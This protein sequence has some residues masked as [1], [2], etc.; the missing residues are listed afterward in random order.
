MEIGLLALGIRLALPLRVAC[1]THRPGKT[2]VTSLVLASTVQ[3]P[4]VAVNPRVSSAA[5]GGLNATTIG[6]VEV[7]PAMTD[8]GTPI[9]NDVAAL[10]M[11]T[12]QLCTAWASTPATPVAVAL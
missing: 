3:M 2:P 8:D 1:T 6:C 12:V 5:N 4:E 11:F 9:D 10:A 7:W